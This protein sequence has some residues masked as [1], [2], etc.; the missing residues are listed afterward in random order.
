MA[1]K[2]EAISLQHILNPQF[3]IPDT[4]GSKSQEIIPDP[5][6]IIRLRRDWLLCANLTAC[7]VKFF[8][9]IQIQKKCQADQS[10]LLR[11]WLH[12]LGG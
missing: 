7:D 4:D 12:S 10:V 1:Q 6:A 9:L 5:D 11:P 8:W 2:V 3:T